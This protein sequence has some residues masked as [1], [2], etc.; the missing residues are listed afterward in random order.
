M[1]TGVDHIVIAVNDLEQAA[2]DYET[3][4]GIKAHDVGREV[5]VM[6]LRNAILPLGD[7]GVYIELAQPL[8]PDTPVGRTIE[9]RGEGIH[10]IAMRVDDLQ[11]TVAQ[12]KEKG[13]QLIGEGSATVVH[14]RETHG[15]ILQMVE[16]T[17]GSHSG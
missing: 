5:Q 15:I 4:L 11:Q 14:P 13:V 6:G 3:K 16:R 2:T 17:D 8:R 1:F 10:S 12:L 9:R 7:S